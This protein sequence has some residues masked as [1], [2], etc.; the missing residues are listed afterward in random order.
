MIAATSLAPHHTRRPAALPLAALAGGMALLAGCGSSGP[1]EAQYT[2]R[3]NAICRNAGAQT[4]PLVGQLTTA[5]GSLSAANPTAA[6]ELASTLE[7]LHKVT[8][9]TLTKLRALAQPSG[10]HA[11]IERFVNS[12][13]TVTETLG[14]SATAAAAGQLQETLAQLEATAADAGQMASAA[15]AHG[16]NECAILFGPLGG[17]PSTQQASTVHGTFMGESHEPTVNRPWHYSITV[18]DARGNKLS[19]TETTQYAFNGAVVGTEQPENVKFT[20]GSY[21]DTIEFPATSVGY[22]LTV[23]AVVHTSQ[24]STTLSWPVKVRR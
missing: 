15:K 24:G 16:L 17:T 1:T 21:G 5:A 23:Q 19:G 12:F 9:T 11:A 10:D 4:T 14:K 7:R 18:S 2:A 3:A 20:G 22:P 13:A 6:H 8:A